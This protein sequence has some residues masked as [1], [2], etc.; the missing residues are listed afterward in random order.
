MAKRNISGGVSHRSG[1]GIDAFAYDELETI[2]W[3]TLEVLER[4]GIKV[5]SQE[6]L[7]MFS[8]AGARVRKTTGGGI[9]KLPGYLV[10]EAIHWAPHTHVFC[11]R[12][13]Q[14]DFVVDGRRVGFTAGFGEHVKII[15]L[16]NR[17][18][19]G[20]VK[21][22][23]AEITRIQDYM[24]VI[25]V[26]ER[27][28]CSGDQMPATQTLHNFEAMVTNT[29]KHCFLGFG[30]R[31][32]ARHIIAMAKEI[33]GGEEPFRERPFVT[34][35]V[36]PTSPLMLGNSCCDVIIEAARNGMGVGVIAMSMSGGSAPATLAGAV[37]QHNA[38]VLSAIILA[39]L[40][41][42]GTPCI[43]SGCSTI[44]DMQTGMSPVGVPEMA[45][46]SV[47]VAKLAQFYK[48]PS[49]VG[50][51]ASDSKLPDAQQAYD[52][53]LT[54]IPAALAGANII[55]GIGAIESIL[56]FDYAA[57]I[58]GAEQVERIL[59]VVQ[60][61]LINDQRLAVDLIHE[62]G[63]GGEY[64]TH[65]HTFTHM[66]QLS[67]ARLFDRRNR[68]EWQAATDGRDLTDRAYDEARRILDTHQPLPL[69]E[70]SAEMIRSVI[71][72]YEAELSTNPNG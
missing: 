15:D 53:S 38:E 37:V 50:A 62:V 39:Q 14:D 12:R 10:E 20:M 23:L 19:R 68:D 59:R 55:Y 13:P 5:E 61:L 56:T 64:L 2:H 7:E 36:C 22:D 1:I 21:N 67:R 3:A 63:P 33:G 27:A 51:C 47:A 52:F 60:G 17:Q 11:G 43:Y 54:A 18:I 34:P 41:A 26:V 48:L 66:H 57:M 45:L 6:A 32:N 49:W 29:S 65:D 31:A 30:S 35:M 8:A 44:M 71:A 70:G 40:V 58:T 25:S 69:P 28:A 46:L 4:T 24:E 72:E 16:E 42:K 9:V